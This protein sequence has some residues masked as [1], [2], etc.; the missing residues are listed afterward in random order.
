VVFTSVRSERDPEGYAVTADRMVELARQQPGFL[1]V[2]SAREAVGVTVSYWRDLDS[3]RAWKAVG[4]HR[5]AQ[6]HGRQE[7]YLAYTTR[8]ARVER[9]Y[10]HPPFCSSSSAAA[11]PCAARL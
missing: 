8:I 10:S 11:K 2:E 7:W 4:E 1:G 9:A 6:Q 3:I 5:L